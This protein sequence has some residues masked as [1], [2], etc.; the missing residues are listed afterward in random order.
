MLSAPTI[1]APVTPAPA[2]RSWATSRRLIGRFAPFRLRTGLIL[3]LQFV[4]VGLELASPLLLGTTIGSLDGF[5]GTKGAL[6][7]RF[8]ELS[9]RYFVLQPMDGPDRERNTRLAA[10]YCLRHPR[11]RL[12]LQTH[13]IVGLP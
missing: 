13:K 12:G 10:E 6:P 8:A 7:E 3:L 4:R 1:A 9:F 5:E 2:I 11:W